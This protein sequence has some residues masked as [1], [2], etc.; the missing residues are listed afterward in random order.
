MPFNRRS[1]LRLCATLALGACSPGPHD[2]SEEDR[3]RLRQ[4]EANELLRSGSGPFGPL[5]FEGYRDLARLDYFKLTKD[6][7]LAI[8]IDLPPVVDFHTHL[9]WSYFLAPQVDLLRRAERTQYLMDCDAQVP[10]C[11][12]D[13]DVYVNSNFTDAM[14]ST[15]R[16]ETLRSLV[17][18]SPA[19]ATHTIP[20]LLAE[21]EALA[22]RYAAVLPIA[23]RLPFSADPTIHQ[24]EAISRAQ[25]GERLLPFASV[26]PNDPKAVAKLRDYAHRGVHGVKLHPEMQRF[27]PDSDEAMAVYAECEKLDL[28]VIFHAGRSGIEPEFMRPYALIRRLV[29]GVQQFPGVRFVFGHAGARDSEEAAMVARE[30]DNVWLELSSQGVT[31]IY[32]LHRDLG[33]TKLVYGSDW[34]FYPQAVALAKVLL[35]T[36]HNEPA[37]ERILATNASQ[38]LKLGGDRPTKHSPS[39]ASEPGV[40]HTDHRGSAQ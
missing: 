25:V 3:E 27:Y 40:S 28:P 2:Y 37:R 14:R 24:L 13:L 31:R 23:V 1:F 17:L 36:E 33:S 4:Q 5:V 34:P 32:E 16:W 15:L 26:H 35:V 29:R 7:R 18:G 12:L 10:P 20:N 30:H 6:G 21:M 38:L 9:G 19:A 8:T 11:E 39:G 22:I